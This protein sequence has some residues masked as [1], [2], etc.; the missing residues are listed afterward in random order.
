MFKDYR[1]NSTSVGR[2]YLHVHLHDLALVP[3]ICGC[4]CM[5]GHTTSLFGTS[6]QDGH[7]FASLRHNKVRPQHWE[8]LA[9]LFLN[10]VWILLCPTELWT[11]KSW[12]MEPMVYCPYPRRLKSLTIY[13]CIITKAVLSA[14]LFYKDLGVGLARVWTH[15]LP[16]GSPILWTNWANRLA[17]MTILSCNEIFSM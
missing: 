12:E 11:M 3:L 14:R 9:L 17:V 10:S 4:F 7:L 5:H 8:L 2:S 15:D 6:C 16:H 13:R 1:L